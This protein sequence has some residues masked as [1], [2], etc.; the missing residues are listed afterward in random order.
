[1]IPVSLIR[2]KIERIQAEINGEMNLKNK[3]LLEERVLVLEELLLDSVM[4]ESLKDIDA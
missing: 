2:K 1:M 4:E 3:E